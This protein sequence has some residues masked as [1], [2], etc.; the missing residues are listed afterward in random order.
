[1]ILFICGGA[2]DGLD[3]IVERRIGRRRVGYADGEA[4]KAR[5]IDR[6]DLFAHVEP[7]DLTRYGLIP[8][9]VGRLP[10]AV[11]LESLDE[12]ALVQI[13]QEPKNA[14]VKQYTKML[15]LEGIGLTFDPGALRAIARQALERGTGARGLRSVIENLMRDLMF[16]LPSRSD[17]REIVI[18]PESVEDR[19]QPLLVLHRENRK[20]EA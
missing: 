11:H 8:E 13:L 1:N 17:V 7:E 2:F 18:T 4:A 14:L 15:E 19:V 3:E 5:D 10:V 6:S 20:R 9:L 12:S 16:D